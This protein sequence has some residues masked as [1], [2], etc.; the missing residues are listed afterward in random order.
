MKLSSAFK[1]LLLLL[2]GSRASAHDTVID[3]LS[4]DDYFSK[5]LSALELTD[6]LDP[7]SDHDASMTLFAPY[8][9]AFD[10]ASLNM[11]KLL[12]PEWRNHLKDILEYHILDGLEV[13]DR[14][15]FPPHKLESPSWQGEFI[16]VTDTT[17]GQ[18]FLNDDIKVAHR[19]V[20]TGNGLIQ[21]VNNVLKPV[22]ATH[23]IYEYA[24]TNPNLSVVVS[25]IEYAG[26]IPAM[27]YPGPMTFFLPTDAAFEK[28]SDEEGDALMSNLRL[29]RH[30]IA[31]HGL[32]GIIM[33]G[34]IINQNSFTSIE[35]SQ[36]EINII[37]NNDAMVVTPD[38]LVSN[39]V[40]HLIDNILDVPPLPPVPPTIAPTSEP[41]SA[42]TRAPS[43]SPT[44]QPS[45]APSP[46]P[47]KRPTPRPTPSP[48]PEPTPSPSKAPSAQPSE[49]PTSSPTAGTNLDILARQNSLT[50]FFHAAYR[51]GLLDILEDDNQTL[52]VFAPVNRAFY[53]VFATYLN[54]EEFSG[55]LKAAMEH[56]IMD[57]QALYEKDLLQGLVL[58]TL[59]GDS[60]TVTNEDPVELN[61]HTDVV[62]AD[63]GG[64]NGVMHIVDSVLIPEFVKYDLIDLIAMK[65]DNPFGTLIY[66][67]IVTDLINELDM[68]LPMTFFTPTNE[69]FAELF[70][71]SFYSS[72]VDEVELVKQLLK[73]HIVPQIVYEDELVD[74][75]QFTTL[76]GS[77]L[78]VSQG[79][80]DVQAPT[81]TAS[82][83][84]SPTKSPTASPTDS[85][86]ESPT[87]SPTGSPTTAPTASPTN[88]PTKSPTPRPTPTPT[89]FPTN[90]PTPQPTQASNS[91]GSLSDLFFLDR[92]RH[93]AEVEEVNVIKIGNDAKLV[94]GQS[95]QLANFGVVHVI[96]K[97]L[98]PA[99][100]DADFDYMNVAAGEGLVGD[101]VPSYS[102][103]ASAVQ[104]QGKVCMQWGSFDKI[105]CPNNPALRNSWCKYIL[106]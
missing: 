42:P 8:N 89:P 84:G 61:L 80:N 39:G 47:T 38:I 72:L 19:D 43:P 11:T 101:S 33:A 85:P 87:A 83:T 1:S 98:V 59:Q 44:P 18:V 70:E 16:T 53:P 15:F 26:L 23:T 21:V 77:T 6:L 64:R 4:E 35:G 103:T 88:Q 73:Y 9:D 55:H 51:S 102:S 5:F 81:P 31:Y 79:T 86:T 28:L 82:P 62:V 56:H 95:N 3:Q 52:T 78:T 41:S 27:S 100:L 74:G 63:I 91:I 65:D 37:L 36:V 104:E 7:L 25:L 10:Q 30:T 71:H 68:S 66:L 29:L 93:L 54:R 32:E 58:T 96:D 75:A 22:S 2:A 90:R 40:I 60:V 12:E 46:G 20:E 14:F 57:G 17:N 34:D 105:C 97:V 99:V 92:R 48:S 45:P 106:S 24:K 13:T 49:A 69:A 67:L 50:V 76:Q 94:N